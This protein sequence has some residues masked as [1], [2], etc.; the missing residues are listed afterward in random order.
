MASNNNNSRIRVNVHNHGD[1]DY[2]SHMIVMAPETYPQRRS[3][4]LDSSFLHPFHE[5]VQF[6]GNEPPS[7]TIDRALA[8]VSMLNV[9]EGLFGGMMYRGSSMRDRV[10]E[11]RVMEIAMRE[12]LNHYKT[13]EKKPDVKLCLESIEATAEHIKDVCAI[14]RSDFEEKETITVLTCKHILHTQCINEWVKYKSECPTCRAEIPTTF[15]EK[16]KNYTIEDDS[17]SSEDEDENEDEN[18]LV[19]EYDVHGTSPVNNS[20]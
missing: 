3:F 18:D 8:S 5:P 11:E 7:R 16:E 19:S 4:M 17:S 12:S 10:M 20:E 1:E 14:C 6:S 13:H 15:T 9:M 2:F